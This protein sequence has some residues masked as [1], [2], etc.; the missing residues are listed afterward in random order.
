MRLFIVII[1]GLIF[2]TCETR[3]ELRNEK[4][5]PNDNLSLSFD[6]TVD[7]IEIDSESATME[8]DTLELRLIEAGLINVQ[9]VNPAIMVDLKYSTADNFMGFNMYGGLQK[10]YLQ[11]DVAERLGE[12][13]AFLTE[14]HPHLRLYVFDA[15]RPAFVQEMMW[16]ALDSIPV[17]ERVKFVSNPKNRSIHNYGAAVDLSLF[18][19]EKDTLLDMGAGYDDL[20]KIAYPKHE[21]HFLALGE[22]TQ[23][24]YKNRQLLRKAMRKGG[25]WVLPTEWWHFNAYSRNDA[26]EKFEFIP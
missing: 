8:T 26:K 4:N 12:V 25:F 18:D 3:Q 21:E 1:F 23:E 13:Q 5:L 9:S 22:L 16:D 11:P 15:V 6:K 19:I 17:N 7:T 14:K 2:L 10:A 20:R 24:Q